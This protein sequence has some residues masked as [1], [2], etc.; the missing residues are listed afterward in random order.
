V[1]AWTSGTFTA[2]DGTSYS[3]A[4][5]NTGTMAAIT[6]IYLN[7][8]VSTTQ[9][10]VTTNQ[11]DVIGPNRVLIAV[12]QNQ[13][14]TATFNT[15]QTALITANNIF[16]N[17]LSAISAN[18]GTI[19]AGSININNLS[20]IGSDGYATFIG[21][22][23]LNMKAYTNFETAGRFVL[24]G[25][26]PTFSNNGMMVA[27]GSSPTHYSQCL[28]FVNEYILRSYPTF[29]CSLLCGN[30]NVAIGDGHAVIGLG[31]VTISGT[32]LT[33]GDS[34]NFC[35][36]EFSKNAGVC[37]LN[38]VQQDGT[39]ATRSATL[40]TLSN[41]DYLELFLKVTSSGVNYYYRKNGGNIT[42]P[43]TVT[44]NVPS[45]NEQ[46]ISFESTNQGGSVDFQLQLQCAAYEH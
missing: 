9:Y 10:Q 17:S 28:W 27:P 39:G 34:H 44:T 14:S 13:T 19:T 4:S 8:A 7:T 31:Y 16:V 42:G 25:V 41:G 37:N 45:G 40:T 43:T 21:V 6:Y 36:F 32:D 5:G 33:F 1:V 38:A 30:L 29:T 11:A 3:I 18:L 23:T 2:A 46:Y 22:S 20:F 35:G 12:A 15:V 26:V 24:N